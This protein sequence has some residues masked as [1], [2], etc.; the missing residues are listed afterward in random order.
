MKIGSGSRENDVKRTVD[1]DSVIFIA[2]SGEC[3]VMF[4]FFIIA[5]D[6]L[7]RFSEPISV[8]K[9]FFKTDLGFADITT[10]KSKSK[11]LKFS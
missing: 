2:G 1:K 4:F 9:A 5:S 6:R 10:K 8:G 7:S 3:P 11:N